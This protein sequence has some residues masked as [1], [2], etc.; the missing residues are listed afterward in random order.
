MFAFSDALWIA[1]QVFAKWKIVQRYK[2]EESFISIAFVVVKLQI[3]KVL[4]TKSAST[5]AHSGSVFCSL[6]TQI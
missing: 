5:G 2:F 6:L 3:S 4:R 1:P